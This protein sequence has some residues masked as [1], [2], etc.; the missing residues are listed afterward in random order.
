M[1]DDTIDCWYSYVTKCFLCSRK[2]SS[3]NMGHIANERS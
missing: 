1:R 3:G 2:E